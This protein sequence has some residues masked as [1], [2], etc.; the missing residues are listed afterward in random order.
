M[1]GQRAQPGLKPMRS[2]RAG[3]RA[4]RRRGM[5]L[6]E[7]AVALPVVVISLFMF[8]QM[9]VAGGGLRDSGRETWAAGGAAQ[10]VL[11]R[12]RNEEMVDV[13]RLYNADA[14]DDP[15]GPGTAPGPNFAVPGLLPLADD[16]DGMVGEI[17]L[18]AVNTGSEV[19]PVWELRED[20]RNPNLGLP[21]DLNGDALLDDVDHAGDYTILPVL[22]RLRWQGAQGR[23]EFR[24][25]TVFTALR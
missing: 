23:R 1:Q 13:F 16:P 17:L 15:G 2:S 6:I 4:V 22:V 11:E 5:T 20:V 24:L 10:D 12:M 19:V 8:L 7:V 9:F 14:F 21:R 25:H 3:A 18:P